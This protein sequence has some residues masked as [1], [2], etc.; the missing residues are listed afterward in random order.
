MLPRTKVHGSLGVRT[1]N[2]SG[3]RRVSIHA[4]TWGATRGGIVFFNCLLFQSTLP[5]GERRSGPVHRPRTRGFNPRSHV[6]SD[7]AAFLSVSRLTP[8]QSTLPCGERHI[9]RTLSGRSYCFNPR[10]HVGSDLEQYKTAL[11]AAV[12]IHAPMWGATAGYTGVFD[13]SL[14]S[15]HAPMWGATS[16]ASV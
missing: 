5:R 16:S 12:S 14:V 15:I 6:R 1:G 11:A 13:F 7:I 3:N 10:S 2:G 4:P 8:F 9:R